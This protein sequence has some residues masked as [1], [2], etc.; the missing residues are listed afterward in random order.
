MMEKNG[1]KFKQ[2]IK[3]QQRRLGTT[4]WD[5]VYAFNGVPFFL[6]TFSLRSKSLL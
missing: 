5:C 1:K 2:K 6:A 3:M 4:K